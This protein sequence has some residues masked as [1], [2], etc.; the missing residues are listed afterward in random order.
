MTGDRSRVAGES[1]A[2]I[3]RNIG[4]HDPE[5]EAGEEEE[6][7]AMEDEQ[8]EDSS[9]RSAKASLSLEELEDID[10]LFA[11]H[12]ATNAEISMA[13]VRR[14]A[15]ESLRLVEL[16]GKDSGP[17]QVYDR[18][19]YL[20]R[21][22]APHTVAALPVEAAPGRTMEWLDTISQ[23]QVSTSSLTHSRSKW[24]EEDTDAVREVFGPMVKAP[25]KSEILALFQNNR[26][27]R[28]VMKRNGFQTCYEKVKNLFKKVKAKK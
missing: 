6:H 7:Q 26:T 20:Q 10:L 11:H 28:E 22:Q 17:K 5:E 27:L 18:I 14:V 9:V 19:K 12:I 2:I 4:L 21:R 13:L 25:A 3:R 1:H 24:A 8:E 15:S 23:S 16:L